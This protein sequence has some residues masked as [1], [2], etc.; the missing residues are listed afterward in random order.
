MPETPA[1][2]ILMARVFLAESRRARINR[3]RRFSFSLLNWASEHRRRAMA[4]MALKAQG[5]AQKTL[6]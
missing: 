4:A 3:H 5:P 2:H 6:F 1:H